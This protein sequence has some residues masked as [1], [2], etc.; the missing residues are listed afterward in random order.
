MTAR[1]PV[2]WQPASDAARAAA[3]AAFHERHLVSVPL[4]SNAPPL[5]VEVSVPD[6]MALAE[7]GHVLAAWGVG[8]LWRDGSLTLTALPRLFDQAVSPAEVG[9]YAAALVAWGAAGR[10]PP[11]VAASPCDVRVALHRTGMAPGFVTRILHSRAC[12]GA[13]MFGSPLAPADCRRVV[14][15]LLGTRLPFQCAHGRP[16]VV[17]ITTLIPPP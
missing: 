16:S 7:W 6:A 12:R 11:P 15:A 9:E 13:V 14:T 2:T 3:L 1:A 4:P 5:A 8:A 10:A 17:P